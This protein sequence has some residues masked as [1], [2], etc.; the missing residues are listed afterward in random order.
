MRAPPR[1]RALVLLALVLD[2][3]LLGRLVRAATPEP[4][5]E[6]LD[7]E[8]VPVEIIHPDGD[9]PWPAWLFVNGAH[10]LR[11]REPVV[12]A[13]SRGLARAGYLVAVPDVPGLGEGTIT[14]RTYSAT[15][16]VVRTVAERPDVRG[17][18]VALIG[19]ST[20]AG[21]ALLA[22]ARPEIAERVSV[23]AVVA[24]FADLRKLICLTTTESY[25]EDGEWEPFAVTDLH[26][27]VVARSLVA[28]LPDVSERERLL[29]ELARIE[30][31]ETNPL[32]EL[33]RRAEA[34]TAEARAALEL[35]SNRDPDRFHD[36]YAALPAPVHA[37]VDELSPLRVGRDV[38][39]AVEIVVPP[40][41]VYFP[42][43]EARALAAALPNARLTVTR[44]LDHTRP[45]LSRAALRDFVQFDRFVIR[46]LRA[47][48]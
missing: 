14:A 7:V 25:E 46:G 4:V 16:A 32:E 18:R 45:Q 36:L 10:P 30:E 12:T 28:A 44:T 47:A 24:P 23:V 40:S 26:R 33:P 39:A 9:G 6:T 19:A 41:D 13:L 37:F 34:T 38:R 48:G 11:R 1:I 17:S 20:G 22:A 2:R 42:L 31:E 35:L 29:S 5:A 8:G 21:L 27:I 15:C 3:P 43:G